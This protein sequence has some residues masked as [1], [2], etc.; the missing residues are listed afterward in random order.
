MIT[1]RK[2]IGN[3]LRFDIFKRDLFTCQY[4]GK[5]PPNIVL[6]IDHI[7]PVSKG[8][9]NNINNLLTSCFNCNRGKN[10]HELNQ[11]PPTLENNILVL[12]EKKKQYSEYLK[13]TKFMQDAKEEQLRIIDNIYEQYFPEYELSGRFRDSSVTMFIEKLSLYVVSEAMRNAC[14]RVYNN[15]MAIKYF[16]GIC[17]AKIREK[18]D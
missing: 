2:P 13:L 4:C 5:T 7:M 16:C 15:N 6:E 8:G 14:S 11:V 1:N 18:Y 9:T 17:W 3:K 12:K 10:K